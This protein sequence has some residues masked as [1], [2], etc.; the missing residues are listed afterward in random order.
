MN[1]RLLSILASLGPRGRLLA[2]LALICA[3]AA[4]VAFTSAVFN[5]RSSNQNTLSAGSVIVG[6]SKSDS[7]ILS[8][9]G[10]SPGSSRTG[11]LSITNN[12]DVAAIFKLKSIGLT[13]TPSSPALSSVLDLSV[14]DITSVTASVFSGKLADLSQM[15]LGSFAAG[16]Q[17]SYR[18]TLSWPASSTNPGL[19]G[20]STSVTFRWEAST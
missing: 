11:T 15:T 19:Q 7:A 8:G 12:G 20:A 4:S 9:S 5:S 18:F 17:R 2:L 13:D 1:T 14:Q 3:G 10:M 6:D 16:E